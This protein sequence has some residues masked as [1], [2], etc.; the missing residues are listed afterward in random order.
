MILSE[1]AIDTTSPLELTLY[2][3]YS[4][5]VTDSIRTVDYVLDS[6]K[7]TEFSAA[8]GNIDLSCATEHDITVTV[9]QPDGTVVLEHEDSASSP[10]E[11]DALS[12]DSL[13]TEGAQP[14]YTITS[15][16]ANYLRKVFH[17]KVS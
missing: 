8:C 11:F 13:K 14:Q 6:S 2:P 17:V 12:F 1:S 4:E 5:V 15:A 16:G 10:F 3:G 9:E 7:A